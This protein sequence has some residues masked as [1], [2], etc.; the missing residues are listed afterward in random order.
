MWMGVKA[1]VADLLDQLFVPREMILRANDRVTVIRL[2]VRTQKLAILAVVTLL[3]WSLVASGALVVQELVIAGKNQKIEEHKLA[4]FDLLAEVTEYHEQ[5]AQITQNL[6][7][8][9][10]FLLSML[11]SGAEPIIGMPFGG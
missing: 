3:G 9:Q 5:F 10:A 8:N 4:Y 1:R 7:S 2:P 6:E 11:E